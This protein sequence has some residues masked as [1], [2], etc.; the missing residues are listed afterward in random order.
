MKLQ[1]IKGALALFLLQ[2]CPLSIGQTVT[3]QLTS[4]EIANRVAYVHG[5]DFVMT[6]PTLVTALGNV[7]TNRIEYG[8]SPQMENEKYPLLSSFPL[9]AKANPTIQGADFANFNLSTFN[10]LVYNLEFFSDKIQVI[11]IDNTNYIMVVKPIVRS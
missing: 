3:Q 4:E 8:I 11:R 1:L 7:M 2:I 5:S 6:N 9:M 10:P